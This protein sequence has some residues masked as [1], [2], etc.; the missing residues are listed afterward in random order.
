MVPDGE[1]Q[2][3]E[4]GLREALDRLDSRINEPALGDPLIPFAE[5]L[6][7]LYS[8]EEWHKKNLK[9]VGVADYYVRRDNN[10]DGKVA[11]GVIYARGL[12][13]HQL[14]VVGKLVSVW[15]DTWPS[16]WPPEEWRWRPFLQLPQPGVKE[17]WGRDRKYEDYVENEPVLKIM[18]T[19]ERFLTTT[20]KSYYP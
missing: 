11:A 9:A 8:L 19:A 4:Q 6:N 7:W 15:P 12:V 16:A 10:P 20:V 14:A 17:K 13:A 3:A 2:H 5:A 18:R 1:R